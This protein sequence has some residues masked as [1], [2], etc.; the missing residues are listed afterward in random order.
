MTS[1]LII[2][3]YNWPEALARVLESVMSQSVTPDEIIIADDGSTKETEEVIRQYQNLFSIPIIHSWQED[4]GFRLSRSRNKAISLAKMDYIIMIDGDMILHQKFIADHLKHSEK[5]F[6]I[7]GKRVKLSPELSQKQLKSPKPLTLF[8]RGLSRG[9]E[10]A[11]RLPWQPN[12]MSKTQ[13]NCVEGIHGCNLAFWRADVLTINGF[14]TQFEGW[15]PEDKEFALRMINNGTKRKRLKYAGVAFHIY[16]D[17]SPKTLL[18]ANRAIFEEI[19]I[20]RARW[21]SLGISEFIAIEY[22]HINEFDAS[23][24]T[25]SLA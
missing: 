10:N 25:H 8:S 23:L 13:K 18:E 20:S 1:S 12:V 22:P 2:T 24:V 3:T 4:N 17:E 7:T 6:F 9:R 21:C 19:K 11:L 16:H 14:N 5:G 15:G